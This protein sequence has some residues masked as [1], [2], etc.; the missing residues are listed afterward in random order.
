MLL[1]SAYALIDLYWVRF[2]GTA[3][4]AALSISLQAFFIILALAQ[5]V[6]ITA[7]AQIS[8]NYGAG[9]LRHAHGLFSSF[10]LVATGI[11]LVAAVSAYLGADPYVRFFAPAPAD[12]A[13]NSIDQLEA[14][15]VISQG[16]VY[17]KI[18]AITFCTQLVIIVLGNGYRGSGDFI[19]P[20]KLM[21][22]AVLI[23]LVLDPLLIFGLAGLPEMGLAGAAWATVIAQ[24]FVLIGYTV[25]LLRPAQS[26]RS[27]R[28][29]RPILTRV[30]FFHLLK[31]GLPVGIQFA[32]LPIF[33][34]LI[35]YAM[36]P[37]G[38]SWTATAGG[39]FRVLQQTLLPMVALGH[40]SAAIAGQCYGAGQIDRV[41]QAS[42]VSSRW[43]LVYGL[44][45]TLILFL[46]GRQIGLIFANTD[47]GLSLAQIYFLWSAPT[48]LAFSLSFV[49][50]SVLQALSR[51]GL[52]LIASLARII[53]L[54]LLVLWLIPAMG[55]GPQ[56]VFGASSATTFLEG[57]LSTWF[58]WRHLIHLERANGG[59]ESTSSVANPPAAPSDSPR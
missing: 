13:P 58:M 6:A 24:V 40:A 25:F 35:L 36:K 12:F 45:F 14:Y 54:T 42:W 31:K 34:G 10:L 1:Q 41:S 59:K 15:E 16:L 57:G 26:E 53:A 5:M 29:S 3:S 8:Q 18:N 51:P 30:F 7:Q 22:S 11:G 20:V 44:I 21:I 49:P 19:T 33:L 28:L 9:K 32:L 52:P 17:F 27:I 38:A 56:W 23:N 2:L 43:M 46:A 47:E 37:F 48:V 39:G 4:V 55:L 50:S